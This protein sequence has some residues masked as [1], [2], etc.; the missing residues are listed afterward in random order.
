MDRLVRAALVRGIAAGAL[1]EVRSGTG[2]CGAG[3]AGFSG[4]IGFDQLGASARRRCSQLPGD[5]RV[6]GEA[7]IACIGDLGGSLGDRGGALRDCKWRI[8]GAVQRPGAPVSL[9]GLGHP[10]VCARVLIASRQQTRPELAGLLGE[11]AHAVGLVI[12]AL[13]GDPPG[14]QAGGELDHPGRRRGGDRRGDT[15]GRRL[16]RR[17]QHVERLGDASAAE[18]SHR[19]A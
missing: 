7:P 6:G 3:I 11:L 14:G 5:D 19:S 13:L 12:P 8:A 15:G 1:G 2:A 4:E 16:P 17:G 9:T 10:G 18:L